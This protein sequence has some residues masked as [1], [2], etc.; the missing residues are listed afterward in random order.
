MLRNT[1][2]KQEDIIYKYKCIGSMCYFCMCEN[3]S[4]VIF[5][6]LSFVVVVNLW[7]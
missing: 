4:F 5:F 6:F 1:Y 3:K 7:S 2:Y